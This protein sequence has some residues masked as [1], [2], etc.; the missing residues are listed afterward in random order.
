MTRRSA[1]TVSAA[2]AASSMQGAG[3]APQIFELR[4][5]QLRNG[6]D[7]QAQRMSDFLRDGYGP[8]VGRSGGKMEGA[9]ANLIAPDGPFQLVVSSYSSLAAYGSAMEKLGADRAYQKEL[10][11]A[12]GKG[13]LNY[14][15]MEV[16]L[17]RAFGSMPGV[18]VG[19]AGKT[20]RVFELRTYESNSPVTLARKIAMFE[21]GGEIAIFR[22]AGI[23]PVFFAETI[24][25]RRMPN[26][27]YLVSYDSLAGREQAWNRFLADPDWAK[28]RSKPGLADAEIV[29]NISNVMLRPLPFS[30]VR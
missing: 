13:G 23:M 26:L 19:E 29:S 28:L 8:A 30:A 11:A 15:R 21:A 7:G 18:E 10:T 4:Y 16:S 24:V 5:F 1:V 9:F 14:V 20:A 25:G 17:L 6:Q 22:K 3:S 2:A 12:D 27:T